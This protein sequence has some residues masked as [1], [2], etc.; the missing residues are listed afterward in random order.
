MKKLKVCLTG[1]TGFVG[2][3]LLQHLKKLDIDI[4][5]LSRRVNPEIDGATKGN[6]TW[7]RCNGFSLLDIEKV[8]EDVDIIIYLIH[9]MIPATALFQGDFADFDLYLADNFARAAANNKVKRIIYLSGLIPEDE[10]LSHHLESRL[11]VESSLAAYGTPVTTLR[12]G[13]VIGKHGSSFRILERLVKRLPGFICPAWTK[14]KCQP[15]D[16]QDVCKSIV[17]CIENPDNLKAF[18]DI[19]G[20]DQITYR[21]MLL[22]TAKVLGKERFVIEVPLFSPGLSKLWVKNVTGVSKDL[23]YPLVDSLKHNMVVNE[24]H[25]LPLK[26]KG[27]SFKNSLH[28]GVSK[29]DSSWVR[30]LIDYSGSLNFRWLENVTSFQRLNAPWGSDAEKIAH[31]YFGWLTKTL[32]PIV[33]VRIQDGKIKFFIFNKFLIISLFKS[34]DRS[35]SDRVLYYID[36]GI[37]ARK[38]TMNGRLEFRWVESSQCAIV[39]LQDFRPSLPWFIYK[40]TQAI[41]HLFVMKKFQ[42]HLSRK[43]VQNLSKQ[44]E[45][46]S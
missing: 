15:I 29:D 28:K 4:V 24:S 6:V 14:S 30:I 20:P 18:Y 9:S 10:K 22:E 27:I 17:Y 36:G 31:S 41:I 44:N 32:Y 34:R 3:E 45:K 25:R 38:D 12:A 5:A 37:L 16:I 43:A 33:K 21:D 7:R 35:T 2:N 39:A 13:L 40:Y 42:N 11:E 23:V 26:D 1:A 8:T 46:V 19:G